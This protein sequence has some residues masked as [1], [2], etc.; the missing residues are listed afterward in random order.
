MFRRAI[1]KI[2]INGKIDLVKEIEHIMKDQ[3]K[4]NSSIKNSI[5]AL[6]SI[7]GETKE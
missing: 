3:R 4:L 2:L 5:D 1:R 6:S 7:M